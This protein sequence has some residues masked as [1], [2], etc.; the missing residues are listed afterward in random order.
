MNTSS[1]KFT[2]LVKKYRYLI[3]LQ[4]DIIAKSVLI[5]ETPGASKRIDIDPFKTIDRDLRHPF[6][7]SIL[8]SGKKQQWL[9]VVLEINGKA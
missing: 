7:E 6:S 8:E 4:V 2:N 5:D 9:R 1:L 3:A